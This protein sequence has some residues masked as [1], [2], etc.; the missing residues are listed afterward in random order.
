MGRGVTKPSVCRL[1]CLEQ[2][3]GWAWQAAGPGEFSSE[4]NYTIYVQYILNTLM[5]PFMNFGP[6]GVRALPLAAGINEVATILGIFPF[7][8]TTTIQN[9]R[10]GYR[11]V[12]NFCMGS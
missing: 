9:H 5:M 7:L 6:S 8:L 3:T 2:M 11:G 10:R 1:V 12:S 4:L